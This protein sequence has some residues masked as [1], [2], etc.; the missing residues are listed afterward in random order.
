MTGLP[1][2]RANE[3]T[4]ANAFF[5]KDLGPRGKR[6]GAALVIVQP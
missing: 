2:E 1:T 6:P 4:S 5:D 3:A